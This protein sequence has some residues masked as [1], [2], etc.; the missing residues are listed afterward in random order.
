MEKYKGI[1]KIREG[2]DLGS[3]RS[4]LFPV[5]AEDKEKIDKCI[6]KINETLKQL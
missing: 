1:I 4:P 5:I 3:V 6:S 2:I